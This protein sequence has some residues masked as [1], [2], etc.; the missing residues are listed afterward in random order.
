MFTVNN[1]SI[2]NKIPWCSTGKNKLQNLKLN[3]Y[4][5]K[6]LPRSNI[7]IHVMSALTNFAWSKHRHAGTSSDLWQKALGWITANLKD[8]GWITYTRRARPHC[9]RLLFLYKV[10][11]SHN[12]RQYTHSAPM[13]IPGLEDTQQADGSKR[14]PTSMLS[15]EPPPLK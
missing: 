15:L 5:W 3:L 7:N 11:C 4:M 8:R 14:T 10:S 6:A 1:I 9:H 2:K 12:K 13:D